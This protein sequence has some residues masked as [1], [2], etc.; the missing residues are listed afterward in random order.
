MTPI[1]LMSE[2]YRTG[3][4][5]ELD[6]QQLKQFY[7]TLEQLAKLLAAENIQIK[8][9]AA[10]LANASANGMFDPKTRVL[11]LA[12]FGDDMLHTLPG[13][14][15][16]E[17]SHALFTTYEDDVK[18]F[19]DKHGVP[20][21]WNI[22]EDGYCERKICLKYPG[23][24]KYLRMRFDI[25]FIPM[26]PMP[27][28][29]LVT[30]TTNALNFNCK[31]LKYGYPRHPYP[32]VFT[33]DELQQLYDAENCNDE[34]TMDRVRRSMELMQMIIA[35]AK[36]E[37]D[38]VAD[39]PPPSPKTA[40]PTDL[41]CDTTENTELPAEEKNTDSDNDADPIAKEND[42]GDEETCHDDDGSVDDEVDSNEDNDSHEGDAPGV[43]ETDSNSELIENAADDHDESTDES[44]L[45]QFDEMF[46][47]ANCID[48]DAE[49]AAM[50]A[51]KA[52]SNIYRL[53]T[54]EQL[55]R[56]CRVYDIM[57]LTGRTNIAP[58]GL[59]KCLVT[60]K[61]YQT[62]VRIFGKHIKT[63][64]DVSQQLFR[65]FAA[66]A[67]AEKLKHVS[68]R[69]TGTLDPT[70]MTQ[71]QVLDDIFQ[72]IRIQPKQINHGFVVMLDW[73]GSMQSSLTA[74]IHRVFELT[75]FAIL[76]KVEMEVWLY[77]DHEM[78]TS[79]DIDDMLNS[80]KGFDDIIFNPAKFVHV[81]STKKHSSQQISDRLFNLYF[82]SVMNEKGW[83]LTTEFPRLDDEAVRQLREY[84][85][86]VELRGTT[87]TEAAIFASGR[88]EA[89]RCQKRSLILMT[90]GDDNQ[91]VHTTCRTTPN[92]SVLAR[93][94]TH[95]ARNTPGVSTAEV[96]QS[97]NL[98]LNGVSAHK[99]IAR[100]LEK[101]SKDMIDMSC[102]QKE[103]D[104]TIT[105]VL[106][107][108]RTVALRAIIDT[109]RRKGIQVT[110]IGWNLADAKVK[111]N[112]F[113]FSLGGT[114]INIKQDFS[115]NASRNR[116]IGLY[117]KAENQFIDELSVRLL[118][119]I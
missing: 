85:E 62:I 67:N 97:T 56:L 69:P 112:S 92:G 100:S 38:D 27:P 68:Y 102:S 5:P 10:E 64:S 117:A 108:P 86:V 32:D 23:V 107:N 78:N 61:R 11:Y 46:D 51:N 72:Q 94:F 63:A 99:I 28:V 118:G 20:T 70:R 9:S 2:W 82:A 40:D 39:T 115:I 18:A 81:L 21:I 89:M 71:Y 53:P 75:Q 6:H 91:F 80:C 98:L 34:I 13:I 87:I 55:E 88:L 33:A 110:S 65:K 43:A 42:K 74:L 4:V 84:K 50:R 45:D 12:P 59:P 93:P 19:I 73:S 109:L 15:A 58:N 95:V 83:G 25:V 35:A 47:T 111:S 7:D 3:K 29:N 54:P 106:L 14:T 8:F 44:V 113:K 66:K 104:T 57:H 114:V 96:V 77:T 60:E 16:H 76:A 17:V 31:A 36:R 30:D 22:I 1:E 79:I 37:D 49:L 101:M 105:Q 26:W 48:E 116:H 119:D 52:D 24:K 90:D 41:D 103:L